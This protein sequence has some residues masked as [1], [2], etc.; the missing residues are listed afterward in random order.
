[1]AFQIGLILQVDAVLVAQVIPVRVA[2]IVRVTYVVDV[3]ALH[4]HDFHLHLFR[5]DGVTRIRVD[6]LAVHA[7]Q[8][9][10]LVIH[11]E[12]TSLQSEFIVLGLR[13]ADFHLTDSKVSGN[14]V[15]SPS[16]L[17][18][19]FGH[20]RIA[21]R[22]FSR[23]QLGVSQ[24]ETGIYRRILSLVQFKLARS[25]RFAHLA[26]NLIGIQ[27]VFVDTVRQGIVLDFLFIQIAKHG[28]DRYRSSVSV[29]FG[30]YLHIAYLHLRGGGQIR[31][32]EDTWQAVHVLC[33]E[34][35]TVRTA[36]HF[37]RHRVLALHQVFRD[38]ETGRIAGILREAYIL[39]VHPE[40]E[41]RVHPVEVNVHLTVFPVVGHGEGTAVRSHLVPVFVGSPVLVR[42]AHHAPFPVAHGYRMFEYDRLITVNGYT[43]FQ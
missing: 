19:Q 33:L 38:V 11:V 36:V 8:L 27:L 10:R 17:V 15:H 21:V 35:G 39:S 32:P 2:R 43:I 7:F 25:H 22:S 24:F 37:Y 26:Y 30:F 23:P 41:E 14:H 20:Q 5:S 12:I 6:F 42:F 28:L 9:H 13:I 18:L 3:T 40:V 31:I 29:Q 4:Q 1:M 34:E 16:F